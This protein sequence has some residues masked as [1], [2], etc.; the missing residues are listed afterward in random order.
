MRDI[1]YNDIREKSLFKKNNTS[2]FHSFSTKARIWLLIGIVFI[3][4]IIYTASA[5][6][7]PE[8]ESRILLS[9]GILS[10]L[11]GNEEDSQL[12]DLRNAATYYP[13]YPRRITDSTGKG[14]TFYKPV[15]K[16]VILHSKAAEA[17]IAL[18]NEDKVVG[19]GET[20]RTDTYQFPTL[21]DVPSVG[22]WGEPN[23][24][25]ILVLKPDVILSYVNWP[26]PEKL[27]N[28]LPK[29]TQVIRMDFYKA[30]TFRGEMVQLG[31]LL[32]EDDKLNEYLTWYDSTLSLVNE[33][34]NLNSSDR[35]V[36]VYIE[37][38]STSTLGRRA[39]SE[40]M[41]LHD[42]VIATGGEN[43]AQGYFIGNSEVEPEWI[44]HQN[45]D[46]ILIDIKTLGGY[47]IGDRDEIKHLRDEMFTIPG[48]EH[49]NAIK[50]ERVYIISNH[51][52]YGTSSPIAHI[53]VGSWLYPDRFE[54]IN[55]EEIHAEYLERFTRTGAE[56]REQGTFYYP[57]G[58]EI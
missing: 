24:E 19:I 23:I 39:Y 12:I 25:A 57:D 40:G 43:V 56:I 10:Y 41:G 1:T 31:K 22:R 44:V 32:N 4:T 2:L 17:I 27:E 46:V 34:I 49:I 52:A 6:I 55:T 15:E 21:T 3:G 26:E 42:L 58:R 45:P 9:E 5:E 53:I 47:K 33:K 54:E 28:Q 48:F 30:E 36:R 29:R 18:E 11:S 8:D 14:F 37:S 50:N 7:H 51:F 13:E 20:I 35:P 16:I 38:G